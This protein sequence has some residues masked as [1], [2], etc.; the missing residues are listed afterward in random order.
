[1]LMP[2]AEAP[3]IQLTDL[4]GLPFN[5]HE[6]ITEGP[7]ILAFFKIACHT[8]QMTFPFLQRIADRNQ[9]KARIIAISQDDAGGTHEFQQR[10]GVSLRTLLDPGPVYK[11]SNAY[12]IDNVPSIFL[13]GMDGIV[14]LAVDGFHKV[15]LEDIG[16][17][18]GVETFRSGEKVPDLR[19]G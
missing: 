14:G 16:R 12:R 6:S 13:V 9:T 8:C 10:V 2:G 3:Q 4:D 11:A 5:L 7:V 19:P 18:C 15:A 17:L 1:M